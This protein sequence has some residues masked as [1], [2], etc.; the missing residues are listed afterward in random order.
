[1]KIPKSPARKSLRSNRLIQAI[2]PLALAVSMTPFQGHAASSDDV[3]L[4]EV[5]KRLDAQA[6][7]IKALKANIG[8]GSSSSVPTSVNA[9]P[10]EK[11]QWRQTLQKQ[12]AEIK[13]L[14]EQ[15]SDMSAVNTKPKYPSISFHGFGDVNY[16]ADGRRGT[17]L[18]YGQT[19]YGSKNGAYLGELDLFLNAQ[20]AENTSFIS[21]NVIS[22]GSDNHSGWD[23]ERLILEFRANDYFNIDIGRLHT[24]LGYYNTTYHHGSWLQNAVGRPSFLQFEDSGGILP[25]HLVG[26]SVHGKVE[27]VPISPMTVRILCRCSSRT[28]IPRLLTLRWL[29]NPSGCLVCSAAAD[30]IMM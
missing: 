10:E 21:E 27:M 9:T 16:S 15:M 22:I 1:M 28:A 13:N 19:F 25:V 5:L 12:E 8:S 20:L 11:T 17:Q 23:I 6:E 18:P 4:K 7:E 3:A 24:A 29:P 2:V 30:C 14:K 26:A